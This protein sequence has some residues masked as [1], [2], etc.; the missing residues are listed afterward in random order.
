MLK[1]ADSMGNVAMDLS[2]FAAVT[3]AVAAGFGDKVILSTPKGK[4]V[5]QINAKSI[6][7]MSFLQVREDKKRDAVKM[8][9]CLILKFGTSIRWFVPEFARRL[10]Q[11]AK[12]VTGFCT[13]EIAVRITGVYA[14]RIAKR[15]LRFVC[16]RP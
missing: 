3:A 14:K 4:P 5:K 11:E 7:K 10:Y 2:V 13:D 12:A 16:R 9:V 6:E 15:E 8:E 1:Y